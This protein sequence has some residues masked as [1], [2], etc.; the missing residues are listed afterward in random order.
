MS[1][2]QEHDVIIKTIES[3]KDS[4]KA[5]KD[6]VDSIPYAGKFLTDAVM[7]LSMCSNFVREDRDIKNNANKDI[8]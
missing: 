5:I 6:R 8:Q 3:I 2:T 1:N 4:L 7:D